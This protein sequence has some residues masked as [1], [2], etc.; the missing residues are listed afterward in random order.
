MFGPENVINLVGMVG[1]ALICCYMPVNILQFV[2]LLFKTV[3]EEGESPFYQQQE[4]RL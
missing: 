2:C 1:M 4:A 3:P